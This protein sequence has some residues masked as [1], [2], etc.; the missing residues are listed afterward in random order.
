M[1]LSDDDSLGSLETPLII[2]GF[3][4]DESDEMSEDKSDE[5]DGDSDHRRPVSL[6]PQHHE[7]DGR[8]GEDHGDGG[9]RVEEPQE[10]QLRV[11]RRHPCLLPGRLVRELPR[12][13]PDEGPVGPAE[14]RR[15][16][17]CGGRG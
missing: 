11:R 5:D 17:G 13:G 10:G 14:S 15:A 4:S 3:A 12:R 16:G 1:W 2:D 9:K 8:R 6:P 7:E